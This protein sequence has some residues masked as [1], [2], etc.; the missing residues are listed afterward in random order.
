[1]LSLTIFVEKPGLHIPI[2]KKLIFL[3]FVIYFICGLTIIV[4]K[5]SFLDKN[6]VYVFFGL[7]A[8]TIPISIANSLRLDYLHGRLQGELFFEKEAILIEKSVF[9]IKDIES[10]HFNCG[11]YLGKKRIFESKG[12]LEFHKRGISQGVENLLTINTNDFLEKLQ[13]RIKE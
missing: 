3:A 12:F 11:D 13:H 6:L 5:S 8:L 7:M 1:M 10:L 4:I 9:L 2:E